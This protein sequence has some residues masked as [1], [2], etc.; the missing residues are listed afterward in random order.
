ME[1]NGC[2]VKTSQPEQIHCHEENNNEEQ[3]VTSTQNFVENYL[4]I[5][6]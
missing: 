2:C 3:E 6:L 4:K 1:F 5:T